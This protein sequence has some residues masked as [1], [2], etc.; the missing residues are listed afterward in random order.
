[1]SLIVDLHCHVIPDFYWEA[2]NEDGLRQEA[3]LR[4]AGVSMARSR[5]STRPVST[6][7]SRRSAPLACTSVTMPRQEIWRA[8]PAAAT[9]ETAA[10]TRSSPSW[11][12]AARSCSSIPRHPRTPIAH[13]LGPPDSLLDYPV[14]T[15]RA[16][17]IVVEI[18]PGAQ[19]RGAFAD[20]LPRLP[21]DTASA[22]SDPGYGAEQRGVRHRLSVPAG[23]DLDRWPASASGRP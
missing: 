21:W 6:S 9:W 7:P 20:A 19:E 16:V 23:H 13:T 15:S 4:R 2:S 12:G 5:V 11:N 18:I 22:F 1:M 17:A 8:V 3:S 10:S 14:D